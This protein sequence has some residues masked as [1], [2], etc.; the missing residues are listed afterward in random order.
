MENVFKLAAY[1]LQVRVRLQ[2]C[3]LLA[4]LDRCVV[5]VILNRIKSKL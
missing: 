1:T 4:Q 5:S 3:S 2:K